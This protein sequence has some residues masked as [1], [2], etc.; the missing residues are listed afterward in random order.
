MTISVVIPVRDNLDFTAALIE[1]LE[2]QGGY[3][4]LLVYDNGSIDE[5]AEWLRGRET[6]TPI[7]AAEWTLH[8]MWNDGIRRS[9]GHAAFLN[10]DL[11]LDDEPDWLGRLCAP[12]DDG[13]G[14]TCP[15][16]DGR[17]CAEPVE[18]L[19]G[20]AAG[21]D[22]GTGGLAGFAFAVSADVLA[23]YRF[24]EEL[25][26]WCGDHDLACT[27]LYK[28]IPYGMVRDVHVE[29]IEGGS[30]TAKLHDLS[31]AATADQEWLKN[32][33]AGVFDFAP[34]G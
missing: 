18:A 17:E 4:K 33:W 5:T 29:H 11:R 3:E 30:Q 20:I 10:N 34:V 28:E 21:R 13:W 1:D 9:H 2:K 26:W 31:A 22:D 16:Y 32:K 14:A 7:D 12:L 19:K 27:L 6:V 15:N 25:T 24:P 8:Q 23:W